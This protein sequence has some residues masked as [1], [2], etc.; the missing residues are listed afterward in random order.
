MSNDDAG[1]YLRRLVERGSIDSPKRGYYTPVRSVRVSETDEPIGH[2]DSSDTYPRRTS[3]RPRVARRDGG[4][5]VAGRVRRC[6]AVRSL[7][8]DDDGIYHLLVEHDPTCP[9]LA[10]IEREV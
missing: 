2:S 3:E 1:K 10:Q 7:S 6:Q 8:R 9:R 4:D 5:A